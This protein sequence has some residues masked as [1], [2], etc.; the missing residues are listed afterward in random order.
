MVNG[1]G[2]LALS[3]MNCSNIITPR[4][5]A[6]MVRLTAV[7]IRIAAEDRQKSVKRFPTA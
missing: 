6:T 2:T 4:P 5:P 1:I 7:R 3:G